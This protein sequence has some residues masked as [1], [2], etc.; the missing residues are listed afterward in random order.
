MPPRGSKDSPAPEGLQPTGPVNSESGPP[1]GWVQDAE[2]RWAAPVWHVYSGE[3]TLPTD[4]AISQGQ[5]EDLRATGRV[6]NP[7]DGREDF[8]LNPDTGV[9]TVEVRPIPT[10]PRDPRPPAGQSTP[11]PLPGV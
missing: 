2:G 10:E 3:I 8:V 7:L 1:K 5:V 4:R 9:I 6:G 11:A